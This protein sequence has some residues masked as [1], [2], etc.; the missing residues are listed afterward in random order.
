MSDTKLNYVLCT[1][2]LTNLDSLG[3][4]KMLKELLNIE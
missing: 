4:V 3:T 1:F 2:G